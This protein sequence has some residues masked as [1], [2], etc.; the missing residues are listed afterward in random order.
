MARF[1]CEGAR[2]LCQAARRPLVGA[3]KESVEEKKCRHRN[4]MIVLGPLGG[5]SLR[6][7]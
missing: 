5:L 6:H 4:P 2:A 1:R 3:R 7:R